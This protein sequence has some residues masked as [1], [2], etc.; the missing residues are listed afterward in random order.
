MH[1]NI[2]NMETLVAELL[3]VGDTLNPSDS[4]KFNANDFGERGGDAEP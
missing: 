4:Y 1:S 3:A 2:C